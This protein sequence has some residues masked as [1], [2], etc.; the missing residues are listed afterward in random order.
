M[1]HNADHDSR[2]SQQ[3]RLRHNSPLAGRP[4][5]Y[6]QHSMPRPGLS[7]PPLGKAPCRSCRCACPARRGPGGGGR[8]RSR[9]Q[10]GCGRPRRQAPPA[11]PAA[12]GAPAAEARPSVLWTRQTWRSGGAASQATAGPWRPPRRAV[13]HEV[14][15]PH[16]QRII[17]NGL[18]SRQDSDCFSACS[19]ALSR[20]FSASSAATC[21]ALSPNRSG[22]SSTPRALTQARNDG[23]QWPLAGD[24]CRTDRGRPAA[25]T[26]HP[27][28][29]AVV[30]PIGLP[31]E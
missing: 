21:M 27:V 17:L 9:K 22:Y 2:G 26:S 29:A 8:Q 4:A 5:K 20:L 25:G 23:P 7:A 30:R 31:S 6:P 18:V 1:K 11:G 16:S 14:L 24:A 19:S 3:K 12:A 10:M 15:V 28:D 13:E